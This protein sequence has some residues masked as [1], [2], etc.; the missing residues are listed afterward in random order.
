M[1]L[2]ALEASVRDR[3][4]AS[5]I[6]LWGEVTAAGAAELLAAYE[7]AA[8]GTAPTIVLN[9]RKMRYINSQGIALLVEL[10]KRS[11][12]DHR[13]LIACGLAPHFAEIF[14]ITRL[15]DL[16]PLYED[17]RSALAFARGLAAS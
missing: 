7:T 13:T 17:E 14:E 15:S 9:C 8:A 5:V 2:M 11:R 10:L 12:R 6:D 3:R 1:M 4:A 16:I